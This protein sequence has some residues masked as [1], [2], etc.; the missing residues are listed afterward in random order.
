MVY[1]KRRNGFEGNFPS[2]TSRN[3]ALKYI[4]DNTGNF[5]ANE[6]V[7]I[8]DYDNLVTTFVKTELVITV[9][10]L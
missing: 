9:K 2:F 10:V 8:I 5:E 6:I 3:V 4:E 7:A 1:I